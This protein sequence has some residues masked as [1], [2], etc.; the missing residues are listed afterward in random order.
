MPSL[1]IDLTGG[2]GSGKSTV[3]SLFAAYGI[4]I[5]D[6]DK[7]AH[8]IVQN[9]Q[10]V[11]DQIVAKF[12]QAILDPQQKLNRRALRDIIFADTNKRKWLEQLLHPLI[13]A[14]MQAQAAQVRSPYCIQVIPLLNERDH[15]RMQRIVVVDASE[16]EQIRRI[17]ERDHINPTQAQAILKAQSSRQQRLAI[18]DDVIVNDNNIEHLKQQVQKLHGLYLKLAEKSIT[19]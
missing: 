14:R 7:I 2:V 19:S 16:S 18:A 1:I 10:A 12:G 5:I 9:E 6:A 13:Y 11:L 8:D 3:A 15:Q 17:S 4:E